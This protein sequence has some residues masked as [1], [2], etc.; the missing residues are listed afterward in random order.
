MFSI[1]RYSAS[2]GL[3]SIAVLPINDCLFS[4]LF[5]LTLCDLMD[6]S[7]LSSLSMELFSGKNGL[8]TAISS[9]GDL[10]HLGI[11]APYPMS[12]AVAG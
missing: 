1:I 7:L 12:P 3:F 9:S 2:L 5:C 10:P 8:V 4:Q 11:E 6:S